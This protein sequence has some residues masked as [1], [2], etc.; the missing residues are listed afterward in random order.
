MIV[1]S[2]YDGWKT[3]RNPNLIFKTEPVAPRHNGTQHNN[4]QHNDT[5]HNNIQQDDTQ[6][7][8]IRN[9]NK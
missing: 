9:K 4:I 6:H 5:Q 2:C 3:V 1:V 7:N 8:K